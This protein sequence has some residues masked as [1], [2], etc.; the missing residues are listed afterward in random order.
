MYDKQTHLSVDG[1]PS[2]DHPR[3]PTLTRRF[4]VLTNATCR[5]HKRAKRVM[6]PRNRMRKRKPKRITS[7][8]VNPSNNHLSYSRKKHRKLRTK[9]M[10]RYR[11]R[12]SGMVGG[13]LFGFSE[14]K[15]VVGIRVFAKNTPD[16]MNIVNEVYKTDYISNLKPKTIREIKSLPL[17]I[18]IYSRIIKKEV[19]DKSTS[20][21]ESKPA[22]ATAAAP[23][24][25]PTTAAAPVSSP[26]TKKNL[27]T[28]NEIPN[29]TLLKYV[30]YLIREIERTNP[31]PDLLNT[32]LYFFD[33]IDF[34]SAF[35]MI[36]LY[37]NKLYKLTRGKDMSFDQI[38]TYLEKN[39]AHHASIEDWKAAL[40]TAKDDPET[41]RKMYLKYTAVVNSM[42]PYE[43]AQ[44]ELNA[45]FSSA[46]APF[47]PLVSK[48]DINTN[49]DKT[50]KQIDITG[51]S[52]TTTD[53]KGNVSTGEID[54]HSVWW[55]NDTDKVNY[56]VV[57]NGGNGDCY[58]E[59]I[60]E[61]L[62]Q[63]NKDAA[64]APA[65][66]ISYFVKI[67]KLTDTVIQTANAPPPTSSSTPATRDV[68][69]EINKIIMTL[70]SKSPNTVKFEFNYEINNKVTVNNMRSL[71]V[72]FYMTDHNKFKTNILNGVK[73][74]STLEQKT[75]TDDTYS[76]KFFSNNDEQNIAHILSNRY[77]ADEM[78]I[79]ILQTHFEFKTIALANQLLTS[80]KTYVARTPVIENPQFYII[81]NYTNGNHYE[82]VKYSADDK[83]GE[84]KSWFE[85]KDLPKRIKDQ[86]SITAIT[87]VG[88]TDKN[89]TDTLSA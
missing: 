15:L 5:K 52:R 56:E 30:I 16:V 43:R 10:K 3:K 14:D 58:F 35:A 76:F 40:E 34:P 2:P 68:I 85:Y 25:S 73:L 33:L 49:A 77:F 22:S 65:S 11:K 17:L 67:N 47:D 29:K 37:L 82:L 9:T 23:V 31:H 61:A 21:T 78:V 66:A 46:W 38:T 53:K 18:T 79:D 50:G 27:R 28:Q 20:I 36:T 60:A 86:Y 19:I 12:S 69:D 26:T 6:T 63:Y 51:V 54:A 24:S 72:L 39:L 74:Y 83:N 75:Q 89:I 7:Y 48:L 81:V 13:D 4:G 1:K 64:A 57:Q 70:N 84:H 59:S 87:K 62:N 44:S 8:S 45:L 55:T 41:L 88:N 80:E 42:D 32:F 71:L